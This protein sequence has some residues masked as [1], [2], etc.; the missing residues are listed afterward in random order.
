MASLIVH[1]DRNQAEAAL[2]RRIHVVPVMGNNDEFPSDRLIVDLIYLAVVRLREQRPN[3][4][5]VNLSLGNRF[6]PFHG[7][8]SPWARLLDRLA[9]RFGLLFIVSAGNATTDF[10]VP[11]Y[12]TRFDYEVADGNHRATSMIGA[13]HALIGERRIFSPGET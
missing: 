13:L 6:R 12:A 2:P 4:I 3:V 11:A 1:G 5:I 7:Q 9:G 10:G 8:L